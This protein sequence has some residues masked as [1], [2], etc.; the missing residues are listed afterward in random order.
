MENG[1]LL[2]KFRMCQKDFPG[3]C[4]NSTIFNQNF[5]K[6]TFSATLFTLQRFLTFLGVSAIFE[7]I[8]L[9]ICLV[10]LLS[11]KQQQ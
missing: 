1:D 9:K 2:G 8:F 3:V 11:L 10:A 4:V 6:C 5:K 7:W